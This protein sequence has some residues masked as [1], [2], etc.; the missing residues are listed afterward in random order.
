MDKPMDENELKSKIWMVVRKMPQKRYMVFLLHKRYELSY[1]EIAQV[2]DISINSVE[3]Q[4]GSALKY[5][6]EELSG[7]YPDPRELDQ[8]GKSKKNNKVNRGKA[9]PASTIG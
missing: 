4:M 6:R 9:G 3:I 5:I 2:M 8:P 1:K 7:Y